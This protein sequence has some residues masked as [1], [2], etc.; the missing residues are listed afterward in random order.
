M[1][2]TEALCWI[3][4]S[5]RFEIEVTLDQAQ[6]CAHSGPCDTDVASL[7]TDPAIAPQLARI[8][9]AEPQATLREYGAWS[10]AELSDHTQNLQRIL[11]IA[12]NDVAEDPEVFR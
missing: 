1:C 11:W 10:D 9:P 4:S 5:G 2:T 7:A 6:S 3:A 8:D 12:C